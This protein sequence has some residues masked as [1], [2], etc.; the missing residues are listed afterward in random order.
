MVLEWM[1]FMHVIS[2]FKGSAYFRCN[3]WEVF[4]H[5]VVQVVVHLTYRIHDADIEF[6][7]T[8]VR[9]MKYF[10]SQQKK[11]IVPIPNKLIVTS[12]NVRSFHTS[13]QCQRLRLLSL[14]FF[15]KFLI[16]ALYR[17]SFILYMESMI[18]RLNFGD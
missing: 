3:F 17:L 6:L 2:V 13:F 5:R 12:K 10:S 18:Q 8:N 11:I 9:I 15:A 4:D 14:L 1:V 7:E 16:L